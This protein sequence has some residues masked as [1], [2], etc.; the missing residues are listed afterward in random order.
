[1]FL[2]KQYLPCL[3]LY[4]KTFSQSGGPGDV[5]GERSAPVSSYLDEILSS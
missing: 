2:K 1:M 4:L 5:A 3:D